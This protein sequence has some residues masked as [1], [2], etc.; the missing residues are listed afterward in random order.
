MSALLRRLERLEQQHKTDEL[1]VFLISW[2]GDGPIT[3]AVYGR[4][5][6]GDERELLRNDGE[7]EDDFG[8]RAQ[9][10]AWTLPGNAGWRCVWMKREQRA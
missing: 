3:R 10:W 1:T 2:A 8:I 7:S 4:A 5:L 9:A 6:E